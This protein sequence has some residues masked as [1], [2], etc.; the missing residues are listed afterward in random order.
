M[1]V[2]EKKNILPS[3]P[4]LTWE[5]PPPQIRVN[6]IPSGKAHPNIAILYAMTE[7]TEYE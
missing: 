3:Y 2:I 6:K 5:N 4:Y 7:I 1:S